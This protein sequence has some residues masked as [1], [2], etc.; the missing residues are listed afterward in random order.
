MR[1]PL[2]TAWFALFSLPALAQPV[3]LA[4]L[5][6]FVVEGR[7]V[8]DQR[9]HREGRDISVQRHERMRFVF[10]PDNVIEWELTSTGYSPRGA[11]KGPT[12]KGKF[13]L[14][15]VLEARSLGGGQAVYTFEDGTLTS[16]RTYGGAGGYKRAVSFKRDKSGA[17]TCS[18][19][20]TFMRED[21]VGRV[22]LNSAVDGKSITV[23][24]AKQV[25]SNCT[26]SRN[27]N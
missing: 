3:T 18:V 20:E 8:V 7:V 14:G 2:L 21:G 6:G 5:E 13:V 11:K 15:K 26:L 16:L 27:S 23:L 22:T 12:R 9:L 10:Y 25:S 24:S 4:E 19:S 17:L 1:R